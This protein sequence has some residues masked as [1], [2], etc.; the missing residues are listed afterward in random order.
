[1]ARQ[2]LVIRVDEAVARHVMS[3][4]KSNNHGFASLNEFAEIALLNQLN[5]EEA[6]EPGFGDSLVSPSNLFLLER[7]KGAAQSELIK[8]LPRVADALFVLTN[9]LSPIKTA[10]RVLANL[11]R[12]GQ[13]PEVRSFHESAAR[14]ARE[15]GLRLRKQDKIARRSGPSRR[16]IGYPV[17]EDARSALDRFVFSFTIQANGGKPSG[18]MAILGLA[19]IVEGR[20]VLTDDGWRLAVA[21][22]PL[23]EEA[24]GATLSVEE[25]AI[26]RRQLLSAPGELEAVREFLKLVVRAAGQ[27][28]R[29][30]ELLVSHHND[31]TADLATSHRSAMIGRLTEL[32]VVEALG[33]GPM[34]KIRLLPAAAELEPTVGGSNG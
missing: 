2:T 13:W 8:D 5:A 29:V 18:P 25:V 21:P 1:M 7:P 22:S 3:F 23:I 15:L 19:S 10:A 4:V 30:D 11:G 9:R 34:A 20:A 26:L 32:S 14:S 24:D 27:Q 16:A 12:N 31:W 33:R 17:G 28:S 6:L